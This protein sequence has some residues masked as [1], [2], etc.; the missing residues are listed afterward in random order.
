MYILKD[1][2]LVLTTTWITDITVTLDFE[3]CKKQIFERF[4]QTLTL[5]QKPYNQ[6]LVIVNKLFQFINMNDSQKFHA[7]KTP[8]LTRIYTTIQHLIEQ[9]N[10]YLRQ[11][12]LFNDMLKSANIL[13]EVNPRLRRTVSKTSAGKQPKIIFEKSLPKH[14]ENYTILTIVKRSITDIFS[15][16]SLTSIG[17]TANKNFISM[18]HNFHEVQSNELR[19]T[20]QQQQLAKKFNAMQKTEKI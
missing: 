18:N 5:S 6:A 19:L 15:P 8:D 16:Y 1:Q 2:T 20:H 4:S 13:E 12:T 3:N 17:D 7:K 9:E 10:A 11:I 14:H